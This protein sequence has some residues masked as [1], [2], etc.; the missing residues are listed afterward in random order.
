MV[1]IVDVQNDFIE[2]G[3]LAVNGGLQV[4]KNIQQWLGDNLLID[5]NTKSNEPVI[6]TQDWHPIGHCSFSEWPEHCVQ[7]TAGAAIEESLIQYLG[8]ND[9]NFC[10]QQ[11]G[12][13]KNKDMYSFLNNDI[14]VVKFDRLLQESD[15]IVVTGIAGT[16]CVKNTIKDLIKL[17]YANK[18]VV[19]IKCVAHFDEKAKQ[20]LIDWLNKNNIKII[21]GLSYEEN[22]LLGK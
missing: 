9:I 6:L 15:R 12:W 3:K 11:K 22:R 8:Y 5:K 21:E 13:E 16:V 1:I 2:G 18:I 19:P 4:S 10:V 14:I 17:G 7:H 20:E